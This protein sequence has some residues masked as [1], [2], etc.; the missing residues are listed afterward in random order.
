MADV[1]IES[2][3][4]LEGKKPA[5]SFNVIW[6]PD[7]RFICFI[8]CRVMSGFIFPPMVKRGKFQWM[9]IMYFSKTLSRQIYEELKAVLETQGLTEKYCLNSEDTVV[10]SLM[11]TKALCHYFPAFVGEV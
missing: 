11:D 8:G 1:I 9:P 5:L 6:Q 7:N 4:E 10:E 3:K 2:V